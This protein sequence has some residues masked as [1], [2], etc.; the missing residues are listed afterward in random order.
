MLFKIFG[1]SRNPFAKGFL[2]GAGAEPLVLPLPH[3]LQFE[4]P[5]KSFGR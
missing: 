2:A 3:K 4:I 1:K 5:C